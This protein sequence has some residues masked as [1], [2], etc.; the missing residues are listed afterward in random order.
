MSIP[1][2]LYSPM[3][4]FSIHQAEPEAKKEKEDRP[5]SP[6]LLAKL[7]APF[8]GEKKAK[9]PKSPKKEKKEIEAVPATEEA[10]KA[11]EAAAAEAPAAEAAAPEAKKEEVAEPVKETEAAAPAAEAAEEAKEEKV[12]PYLH[13]IAF[14]LPDSLSTE[15][16][17][18]EGEGLQ[19]HQD[20]SSSLCPRR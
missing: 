20:R 6:S 16:G 7:L 2:R 15:G 17:R 3:F 1:H 5:K 19:D 4:I 18:E 11:E 12:R 10:P 9:V 14:S 8:K 13:L